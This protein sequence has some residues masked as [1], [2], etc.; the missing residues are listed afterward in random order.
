MTSNP[1][2]R[3]VSYI[4]RTSSAGKIT[5]LLISLNLVKFKFKFIPINN[6]IYDNL[7]DW[8]AKY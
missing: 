2:D 5:F 7:Q 6:N 4:N 3:Q 8:S 1:I